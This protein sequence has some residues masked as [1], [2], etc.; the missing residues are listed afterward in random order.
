MKQAVK[1]AKKRKALFQ[2]KDYYQA[3][4]EAEHNHNGTLYHF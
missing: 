3:V 4:I 2:L 1:S